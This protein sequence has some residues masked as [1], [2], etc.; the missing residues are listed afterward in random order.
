MNKNQF[1]RKEGLCSKLWKKCYSL[2]YS[3][4]IPENGTSE[5]QEFDDADFANTE[6]IV[7]SN[8]HFIWYIFAFSFNFM[9]I[10]LHF[11]KSIEDKNL[12]FYF[13][14]GFSSFTAFIFLF[15][16]KERFLQHFEEEFKKECLTRGMCT[17]KNLKTLIEYD[18][19][20]YYQLIIEY[21]SKRYHMNFSIKPSDAINDSLDCS[22]PFFNFIITFLKIILLHK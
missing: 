12:F 8:S 22:F 21:Y 13:M 18:R 10:L 16:F 3:S 1:S 19:I 6:V 17:E 4:Y 7:F 9:N 14:I 20:G 5:R 11:S 2:F 15:D